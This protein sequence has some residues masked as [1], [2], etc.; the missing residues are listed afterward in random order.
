[1]EF[2][3]HSNRPSITATMVPHVRGSIEYQRPT[4]ILLLAILT[5]NPSPSPLFYVTCLPALFY[6]HRCDLRLFILYTSICVGSVTLIA[7]L[8]GGKE[9]ISAGLHCVMGVG[10]ILG[11]IIAHHALPDLGGKIAW[12][13]S[14]LFGLMWAGC[15]II[16]RFIH[17]V[18]WSCYEMCELTI[19]IPPPPQAHATNPFDSS[20][21][22]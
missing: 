8:R 10:T 3:S 9:I 15:G 18:S 6:L 2:H 11:S 19:R 21:A 12:I 20:P 5:L 14:L 4:V 22:I 13:D 16:S 1:M 17:F 7:E